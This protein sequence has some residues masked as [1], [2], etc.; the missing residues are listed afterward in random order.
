MM[1]IYWM[2]FVSMPFFSVAQSVGEC[3]QL[4]K[5]VFD[6]TMTVN[7]NKDNRVYAIDYGV[8]T[9]SKDP[10]QPVSD[11]KVQLFTDQNYRYIYTEQANFYIDTVHAITVVP[12]SKTIM[13]NRLD[14][15]AKIAFRQMAHV[16]QDSVLLTKPEV[17]SCKV[18]T[19]DAHYDH[20][21]TVKSPKASD[22]IDKIKY[23]VRSSD[24]GIYKVVVVYDKTNK[25]S[26]TEYVFYK[27]N[28][29][30]TEKSIN[31][32]VYSLFFKKDGSLQANYKD[33]KVVDK[34]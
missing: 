24:K 13:V 22:R 34:K 7:L 33:Y 8:K 10:T 11:A 16:M 28:Y 26:T 2:L 29:N 3:E 31:K 17:L 18:T 4:M 23:L 20:E 9:I 15:K 12:F 30:Y 32:P 5:D 21:I 27:T 19:G 25:L 14:E 6:H 1:R